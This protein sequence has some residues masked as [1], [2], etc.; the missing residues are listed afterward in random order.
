MNSDGSFIKNQSHIELLS[1]E[2]RGCPGKATTPLGHTGN[3]D[4]QVRTNVFA[5]NRLIKL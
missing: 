1:A 2:C 4:F 3:F 5:L